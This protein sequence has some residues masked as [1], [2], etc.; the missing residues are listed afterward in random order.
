MC[1]ILDFLYGIIADVDHM[2]KYLT[3]KG[4]HQSAI[5]LLGVT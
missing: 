1:I 4:A 3:S 2:M 5:W